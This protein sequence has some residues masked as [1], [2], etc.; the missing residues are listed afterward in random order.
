MESIAKTNTWG[1][2]VKGNRIVSKNSCLIPDLQLLRI[3]QH[4]HCFTQWNFQSTI[5][6]E[7]S[8]LVFHVKDYVIDKQE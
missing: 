1:G 2:G 7:C 4:F 6:P 5:L 8:V 3:V